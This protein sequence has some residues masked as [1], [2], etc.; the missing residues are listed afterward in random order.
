M[1]SFLDWM[2]VEMRTHL[3]TSTFIRCPAHTAKS[4][5]TQISLNRDV[6]RITKYW[7]CRSRSH[8]IDDC[9]QFLNKDPKERFRILKENHYCFSCLKRAGR[10]H[11]ASTCMKRKHCGELRN[12]TQCKSFHHKLLHIPDKSPSLIEMAS[13]KRNESSS[14]CYAQYFWVEVE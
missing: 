11:R 2:T 4:S 8:F 6:R 14:C 1:E 3:R 5:V 12:G 10:D 9:P 13:I 7:L